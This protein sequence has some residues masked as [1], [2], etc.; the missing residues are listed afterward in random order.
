MIHLRSRISDARCGNS[1][2]SPG[3]GGGQGRLVQPGRPPTR[4]VVLAF[5]VLYVE[6]AFI[7]E[8]NAQGV[9]L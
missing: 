2:A 8:K 1:E 7:V 6:H 4:V 5:C 3:R 9:T